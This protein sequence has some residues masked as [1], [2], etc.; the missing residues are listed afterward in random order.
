MCPQ[1]L[2]LATHINYFKK[3]FPRKQSEDYSA[4]HIRLFRIVESKVQGLCKNGKEKIVQKLEIFP[5]FLSL[6]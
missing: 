4:R 1:E 5:I 3:I 2:Y 6:G